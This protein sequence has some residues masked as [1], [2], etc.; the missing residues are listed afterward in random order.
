MPAAVAIERED[1]DEAVVGAQLDSGGGPADALGALEH[2]VTGID[3]RELDPIARHG[4]HRAIRAERHHRRAAEREHQLPLALAAEMNALIRDERALGLA[5]DPRIH[6]Q[7]ERP[8]VA[9]AAGG[10]ARIRW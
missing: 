2:A 6:R 1:I 9:I 10:E 4:D 7:E 8:V 5:G 3:D